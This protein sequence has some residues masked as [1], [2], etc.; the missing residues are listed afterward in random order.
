[1]IIHQ[2]ATMFRNWRWD[3]LAMITDEHQAILNAVAKV[4]PKAKHRHCVRN[5]FMLWHKNFRGDE[6]N[7]FFGKIAKAYN[8]AEYNQR[9]EEL[10]EINADAA[11]AFKGHQGETRG[12]EG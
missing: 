9:I 4:L 10:A 1:M 8:L 6:M 3:R 5:I 11:T 2:L 7:Y 12:K